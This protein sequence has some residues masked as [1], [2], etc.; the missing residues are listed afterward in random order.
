MR[1]LRA[2]GPTHSDPPGKVKFILK[3]ERVDLISG[4]SHPPESPDTVLES[5]TLDSRPGREVEGVVKP[6]FLEDSWILPAQV[7]IP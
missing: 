3:E 2:A 6:G 4:W 5:Q 7:I 1:Q